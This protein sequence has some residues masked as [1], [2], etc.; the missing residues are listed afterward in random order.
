MIS[1]FQFLD[2]VAVPVNWAVLA[3]M[4]FLID[5]RVRR[6]EERLNILIGQQKNKVSETQ[7]F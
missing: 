4:Y 2:P 3:T 5:R 7:S 6:I 1:L